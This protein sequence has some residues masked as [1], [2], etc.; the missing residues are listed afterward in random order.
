MDPWF[1]VNAIKGG[2]PYQGPVSASLQSQEALQQSEL[3]AL[4]LKSLE[5]SDF[6]ACAGSE[7]KK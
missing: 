4:L 1:R 2:G 6:G 7:M 5:V 3:W